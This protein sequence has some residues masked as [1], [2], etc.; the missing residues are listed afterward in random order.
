MI[1]PLEG[2][3]VLDFSQYLSGPWAATKLADLGARVIKVEKSNGGDACRKLK[4]CNLVLD[5]DSTLFHSINRNKES[6]CV[7]F[8]DPSDME[9]VK[10]L[11]AKA[12]VMIQNYRPG[13][14]DKMGIG[15]EAVK[16]INPSIVY[17]SISGYGGGGPLLKKPGQDLLV[18]ALSGIPWLNGNHGE[19]PVPIGLAAI[20]MCTTMNTV[21]AV[22]ASLIGRGKTGEGAHVELSLLE[23]S[24]DFQFESITTYLCNGETM[25]DRCS[26]SNANPYSAAPYGLYKTTDGYIAVAMGSIVTLG[27]ILGS[28]KLASYTTEA[29]WFDKRDEVKTVLTEHLA[30]NTSAFWLEKLEAADYW[31]AKVNTVKE[32]V[33]D[34]E[35]AYADMFQEVTRKNGASMKTTRTPIRING[36]KL[37]SPK[38]SPALGEDNEAIEK[39]FDL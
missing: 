18:Q 22:L 26:V 19:A 3:L 16:E 8:R 14:I 4:L 23:S 9:K 31:A 5:N 25:Q 7:N 12:D 1:R 38:G 2:I 33:E 11:I 13:I 34:E 20:D 28:E 35:L 17:A 27:E 37:F 24:I 30:T 39:E 10:K 6:Y 29:D 21:Q 32:V 15:Y 36:E